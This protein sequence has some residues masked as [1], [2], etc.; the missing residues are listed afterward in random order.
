M[1]VRN[2]AE[3]SGCPDLVIAV[4]SFIG[5]NFS[6]ITASFEFLEYPLEN[7]ETLISLDNLREF[8]GDVSEKDIFKAV[9]EWIQHDL[10]SRLSKLE[11]LLGKICV[12]RLSADF[13][14]DTVKPFL[15][16][17]GRYLSCLNNLENTE[18]NA[19]PD[20]TVLIAVALVGRYYQ[21]LISMDERWIPVSK[22]PDL[23]FDVFDIFGIENYVAL[24]DN[25]KTSKAA[26][27]NFKTGKSNES[28]ICIPKH[29]KL[30][31]LEGRV[32]AVGLSGDDLSAKV[33]EDGGWKIGANMSMERVGA[34]VVAHVGR[35]YSFGGYQGDETRQTAEVYDPVKDEWE[36]IPPM[37]TAR[38]YAGAAS[39][40][41]KIYVVGGY[42][43]DNEDLSSG[44]CYDPETKTWT[45][46]P[47]MID[48]GGHIYAVAKDGALFVDKNDVSMLI[49]RYSPKDNSWENVEV[50]NTTGEE[51][52]AIFALSTISKK[53]LPKNLENSAATPAQCLNDYNNK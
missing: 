43:A 10:K 41:G 16:A 42:G 13:I 24:Y 35:I 1:E 22:I 52:F 53:Y 50:T 45:R 29:N 40:S 44:E 4:D 2:L 46:I 33:L 37:S 39:L 34:S 18:K 30:V 14:E 17:N 20:E 49:E 38:Y 48:A 8:L 27:Y 15:I 23:Y 36:S 28:K 5:D 32:Y 25:F 9:I 12:S 6:K 31:A 51:G 3:R 11:T 7:V 21:L 47:N 19:E 26:L